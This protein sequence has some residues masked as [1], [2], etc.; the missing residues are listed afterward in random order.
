M[1]MFP[2]IF[3]KVCFAPTLMLFVFSCPTYAIPPDCQIESVYVHPS[4]IETTTTTLD[5]SYSNPN[6]KDAEICETRF[7]AA[8]TTTVVTT[9]IDTQTF[10]TSHQPSQVM[11]ITSEKGLVY[12]VPTKGDVARNSQEIEEDLP[13]TF[14]PKSRSRQFNNG[15]GTRLVNYSD[16][17]LIYEKRSVVWRLS[18]VVCQGYEHENGI[19]GG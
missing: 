1:N 11:H 14:K 12:A 2:M 5:Q 18:V 19:S 16:L 15:L 4:D 17:P 7:D 3:A 6:E 9:S 10:S 13:T 8:T